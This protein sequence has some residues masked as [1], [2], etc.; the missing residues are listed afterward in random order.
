MKDLNTICHLTIQAYSETWARSSAL[1]FLPPSLRPSL[2]FPSFRCVDP[3]LELWGGG[4]GSD[5]P[6]TSPVTRRQAPLGVGSN[7]S[8]HQELE[9]WNLF[10]FFSP[11]NCEGKVKYLLTKYF[12]TLKPL[13]VKP[14]HIME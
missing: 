12:Q 7:V 3:S 9:G 14:R 4:G 11:E 8:G 6:R 5:G 13:N 1:S 10:F 2:H